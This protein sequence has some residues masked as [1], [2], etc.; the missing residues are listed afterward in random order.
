[1]SRRPTR[2]A[3]VKVE[4]STISWP[5]GVGIVFQFQLLANRSGSVLDLGGLL[6]P[7]EPSQKRRVVI[8]DDEETL[9]LQ[10]RRTGGDGTLKEALSLIRFLDHSEVPGQVA[11]YLHSVGVL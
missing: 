2:G 4:S 6:V 9:S 11:E 5:D 3:S 7:P 10:N 1:M 8:E